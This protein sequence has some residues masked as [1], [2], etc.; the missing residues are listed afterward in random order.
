M[1]QCLFY[2]IFL[3]LLLVFLNMELTNIFNVSL[4]M[5]FLYQLFQTL[6]FVSKRRSFKAPFFLLLISEFVY[7]FFSLFFSEINNQTRMQFPW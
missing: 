4:V 5:N 1:L 6:Q 7:I 3:K 2:L